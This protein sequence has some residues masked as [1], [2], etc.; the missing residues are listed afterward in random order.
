MLKLNLLLVAAA[1]VLAGCTATPP[2]TGKRPAPLLLQAFQVR[3][4]IKELKPDT[5][6]I[7]INHEEIPGYMAAMV[8]PFN[9]QTTNEFRGLAA[10]DT[11]SFQLIVTENK[12]WIEQITKLK[13]SSPAPV[14]ATNTPPAAAPKMPAGLSIVPN[15][16][17]LKEGDPLPDLTFTNQAGQTVRFA[18]FHGKA[19][20]ITFIFT[21]CPIPEFCPRMTLNFIEAQNL[22]Q[23]STGVATNWHLL[24]LSF[25]PAFD[26]PAVLQEYASRYGA[27]PAHWSFLTGSPEATHAITEAAGVMFWREKP[28]EPISHNLR[29]VI[30]NAQ[31][32]VQRIL[33]NNDWSSS[34][35]I[36]ELL[37]AAAVEP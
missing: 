20:A 5:K 19:L 2:A 13:E 33:P 28:E 21:R 18:D 9:V 30:V 15:I 36:M 11:I 29:T 26:T 35:L 6:T 4:V 3:G 24:S 34:E 17:P 25:D 12:S 1:L 7:V 27:D 14:A 10:G 32:R 16:E 37:K 23:K 31:G 8:M 22:L